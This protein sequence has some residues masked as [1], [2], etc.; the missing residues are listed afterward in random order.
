MRKIAVVRVVLTIFTSALFPPTTWADILIS[1]GYYDLSPAASG[2]GPALPNPWNGSPNTQ[3]YGSTSDVTASTAGD[4]DISAIL[5]QNSGSGAVV[6]S[7]LGLSSPMD[8]LSRALVPNGNLAAEPV[9]LSP[10]E[11]YIFGVGDG[12]DDGLTNQTISLTLNGGAFSFPD[13]T[14]AFAPDGVLA[15]DMPQLGNED[16]TQPWALDA[17]I[18]AIPEPS[19]FALLGSGLTVVS[20]LASRGCIPR[21]RS[22][23]PRRSLPPQ[24]SL[25]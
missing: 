25:D 21:R 20:V 23:G 11:N 5:L 12:S 22:V 3:F 18:A 2:G 17:D 19:T 8:V 7:A 14:T 1:S 10:G 9:T 24:A 16:E 15:G 4:P 6:L 13:A